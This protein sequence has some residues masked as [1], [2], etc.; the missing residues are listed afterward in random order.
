MQLYKL[1]I[2][3][4]SSFCTKLQSDT[5]FG[6]FCWSYKYIFGEEKLE[7]F[8][9]DCTNG[10][11][12]IVFSD[13][14]PSGYVPLPLG[15]ASL[16]RN[17]IDTKT[18]EDGKA[19]YQYNKKIKKAEFIT[20]E[21]LEWLSQNRFSI[22]ENVEDNKLT[23]SILENPFVE[24]DT[25]RNMVSR[26]SG[27][28]EKHDEA[29]SLYAQTEYFAKSDLQLD[30]YLRSDLEETEIRKVLELMFLLGIGGKKSVGK[31]RFALDSV[32]KMEEFNT[33]A[34]P[35]AYLMLSSYIPKKEES[36]KGYYST[37]VKTPMLDREYSNQKNPFKKPLLFV[38]SGAVFF[39]ENA[40]MRDFYGRCISNT[41]DDKT[42]NIIVSGFSLAIPIQVTGGTKCSYF[43]LH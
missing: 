28:V 43:K 3:P 42:K 12:P 24:H 33:G 23:D 11:P 35:N 7:K 31:G 15:I 38:K 39:V 4:L 17:F 9:L 30:V 21:K 5:F 37:F 19:N 22:T 29:G 36:S 14:F 25:V 27:V 2:H 1:K 13:A 26:D 20:L 32:E 34:T 40:A 18:K 16:N 6:A 10:Q 8:I 41:T